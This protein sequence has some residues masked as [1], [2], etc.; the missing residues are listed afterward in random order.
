MGGAE[1]KQLIWITDDSVSK[2]NS[3]SAFPQLHSLQ[4]A[5]FPRGLQG[6]TAGQ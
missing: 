6:G 3:V 2:A 5:L 1:G 4:L